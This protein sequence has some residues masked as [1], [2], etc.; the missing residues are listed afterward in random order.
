MIR[1]RLCG[2]SGAKGEFLLT[3]TIQNRKRLANIASLPTP[4]PGTA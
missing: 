1:L 3:A 2:L 4:R